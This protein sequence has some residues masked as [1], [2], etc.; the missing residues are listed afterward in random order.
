MNNVITDTANGDG[1]SQRNGWFGQIVRQTVKLSDFVSHPTVCIKGILC[2]IA[3]N[4]NFFINIALI[5]ITIIAMQMT[6]ARRISD[7]G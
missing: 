4:I 1:F 5:I 2:N 3:I 6:M 7:Y